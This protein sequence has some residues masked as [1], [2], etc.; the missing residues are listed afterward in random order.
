[1]TYAPH[2]DPET[3]DRRSAELERSVQLRSP[4]ETLGYEAVLSNRKYRAYADQL[5]RPD[6]DGD[7]RAKLLSSQKKVGVQAMRGAYKVRYIV[8]EYGESKTSLLQMYM[9]QSVSPEVQKIYDQAK[10]EHGQITWKDM[11][12]NDEHAA[13]DALLDILEWHNI[14]VEEHSMNPELV[15]MYEETKTRYLEEANILYEEGILAQP[16]KN[17][18][19]SRIVTGDA[20]STVLDGVG[21]YYMR[22]ADHVVVQQGIGRTKQERFESVKDQIH[23]IVVHEFTHM[24]VQRSRE[25]ERSDVSAR[26]FNEALTENLTRYLMYRVDPRENG[27]SNVYASERE[28]YRL[29]LEGTKDPSYA[30]ALAVRAYSGTYEDEEE[31]LRYVDEG[32]GVHDVMKRLNTVIDME[33]V[34]IIKDTNKTIVDSETESVRNICNTFKRDPRIILD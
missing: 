6:L 11:L 14:A 32:W 16:P 30:N 20:F 21:G 9:D 33:Q 4:K 3:Y 22:G 31:F 10:K 26:W 18:E 28:L 25:G 5:E 8:Q 24:Y 12:S 13:N 1:M 27:T 23:T 34:Q 17:I 19:N 7:E 29:V 2:N 15:K